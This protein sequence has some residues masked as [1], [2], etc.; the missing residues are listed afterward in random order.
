[1]AISFPASPTLGQ[2]YSVGTK[3][4]TWNGYAWD[5]VT[6]NTINI[7]NTSNASFGVANNAAN[8]GIDIQ[9]SGFLNQT[10]T[11]LAFDASNNIFTLADSGSGWSY[12]INGTKYTVSGNVSVQLSGANNAPNGVYFISIANATNGML[13]SSTSQWSLLDSTTLTVAS[14]K[15][16][17]NLTPTYLLADERHAALIDTRMHFYLHTTR[18]TQVEQYG[19][20]S[21]YTVGGSYDANNCF[22]ISQTILEDEDIILTIPA[23]TSSNGVSNTYLIS[24]RTSA[25]TWVWQPSKVPFIYNS[26]SGY[27]QYDNGGT[28]TDVGNNKYVNS[29]L[30]FSNYISGNTG[31]T[32][33][34][35]FFPGRSTFGSLAAAQAE[36][37]TTF[38]LTGYGWIEHVWAY[39]LTWLCKNAF[40]QTGNVQLA[41]EPR[42]IAVPTTISSTS[43]IPAHNQLA[44]LQGGDSANSYYYHLT[45]SEYGTLQSNVGVAAFGLANATYG[46]VNSAFGVINAAFGVANNAYTSANG[47]AAFAFAN[48]VSTNTTAAFGLTNTTYTAV[49]SAFGVINAAFTQSNTDNVR[50]S[51]AYVVVNSAFGSVNTV[52]GYA[53]TAGSY[54]NQAGVIANA[55]FGAA[56]QAGVVANNANTYA[57]STYLPKTGGS[58][59]GDL[60]VSG[61][62]TISGLST[63]LNTSNLYIGDNLITLNA[64]I[65]NSVVPVENAGIEVN[66][67]ARNSNANILWIESTNAWA[68]TGNNLNPITTY[69]ASNTYVDLSTAN[70]NAF[71]STVYTAVNSA[72]AVINAAF[73]HSNTTYGAVNSAFGVINAAFGQVNTLATSANAYASAVG[74]SANAYTV[75]YA[76][77]ITNTA[78]AFGHSNLTYAAVNSA[79]AVINA[80]YTS[81]N[82]NYVVSNAAFGVAN[83]A[84]N[85]SNGEVTRLSAAYVVTNASFAAANSKVATVSGTSGRITSSGTTGI[86]LDLATAGAGAATY[87]SGISAVTV[88]AYGRVTSVTGSAGYVTSSGVTSVANG[89]G[90]AGGTI[91]STGTLSL[92]ASGVTATTYGGSTNIPVVTVDAYGRITSASNVAFSGGGMDYPYVNTST[93][94][95]NNYAGSMANAA[96][97]IATTTFAPKASPT[98]TG[99]VNQNA[100]TAFQ[101]LTD[102]A[103]I[104]WDVSLGQIGT[105]TLTAAGRTMGAPTNLKVGT[106]ILHVIQ[107]ATGSRTITTWNSIFKWP[108]G[109]APTLT[110]T[111]NAR[112]VFS[113]VCDGTN[114][115]GSFLPDVK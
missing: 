44:G 89:A 103:T 56:N 79:F 64:D 90:L 15:W 31:L 59:S 30:L 43:S 111:A 52:G 47:T 4:W 66:R 14:V 57:G 25:N 29:Y 38:D 107:D 99:T 3:T 41:A 18:G 75:S 92:Q 73:G 7:F 32:G 108:G 40:G 46:A 28:M 69:I 62:L 65:P 9:R 60:T 76:A 86:T 51:A 115:Y 81:S 95:A 88:D 19:T 78:A 5:I 58:I 85:Q 27:I 106:Y 24:Y 61:N 11:Y 74:T 104:N 34:F 113:F 109:V 72:F 114:L 80:V 45:Q 100:N 101:T 1:M 112:D 87:S 6:A 16:N 55:A 77:T 68:F 20:L 83:A 82:A 84:F 13:T 94:S 54:A 8:L 91:T 42:K 17:K 63:S 23:L 2:T 102:G 21:G 96:N 67:G 53:N 48:G 71:T 37:P 93:T 39:Q 105:V 22:S 50:L 36:D 35:A 49:N 110:T 97:A 33:A 70:A 98:F 26:S 12:Y 10:Q